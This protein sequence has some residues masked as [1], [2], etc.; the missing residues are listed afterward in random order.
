MLEL[1]HIITVGLAA[2]FVQRYEGANR[3][4]LQVIFPDGSWEVMPE[5]DIKQK[6]ESMLVH[7]HRLWSTRALRRLS[8]GRM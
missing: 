2:G 3:S 8:E 1:Q 6:H 4:W 5:D 7:A